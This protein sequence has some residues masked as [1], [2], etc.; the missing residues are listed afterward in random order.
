[1]NF[2]SSNFRRE[3]IAALPFQTLWRTAWVLSLLSSILKSVRD[4]LCL[5]Y[6]VIQMKQN[7]FSSSFFHL[8]D[9]LPSP[10]LGQKWCFFLWTDIFPVPKPLFLILGCRWS[11][12]AP[13]D[14]FNREQTILRERCLAESGFFVDRVRFRRPYFNMSFSSCPR[15]NLYLA[16]HTPFPSV[17]PEYSHLQRSQPGFGCFFLYLHFFCLLQPRASCLK[18]DRD[19]LPLGFPG[20]FPLNPVIQ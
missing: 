16:L 15:Q 18:P 3:I 17:N 6:G 8:S 7:F 2:L 5:F 13:K 14:I 1:V 12:F 9:F 10:L 11:C 20:S 19:P 4:C